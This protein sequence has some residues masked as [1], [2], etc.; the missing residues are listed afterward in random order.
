MK[1]TYEEFCDKILIYLRENQNWVI[2]TDWVSICEGEEW[3]HPATAADLAASENLIELECEKGA[4]YEYMTIAADLLYKVYTQDGWAAVVNSVD[5]KMRRVQRK[6]RRFQGEDYLKWL[7]DEG[8]A[9]YGELREVRSAFAAQKQLP[10]YFICVNRTLYEMCR[11]QPLSK[12]ELKQV[13]GIGEKSAEEYGD[14]FIGKIREFTGGTK[15]TLVLEYAGT[16]E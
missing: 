11:E 2:L 15:K 7:D 9:L 8:K 16:E 5:E 3:N 10:P 6:G 1:L 12:E 13:Y 14:A 4:F